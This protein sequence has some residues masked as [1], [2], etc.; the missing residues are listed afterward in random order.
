MYAEFSVKSCFD[1]PGMG[2]VL[3]GEVMDG[4]IQEGG[5]GKTPKGKIC[6]V[7]RIDSHGQ[8]L[9]T[10]SRKDKVSLIVKSISVT[11]IKPG[12]ALYFY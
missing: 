3:A 2:V 12:E 7:I 8:K 5:Q 11:D 10:V 9:N 6:T 1:L 4:S